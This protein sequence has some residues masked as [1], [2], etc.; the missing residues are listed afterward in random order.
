MF[1]ASLSPGSV[2]RWAY[3][4]ARY[5]LDPSRP[6]VSLANRCTLVYRSRSGQP[7]GSL[8]RQGDAGFL[9]VVDP[10]RR[11]RGIASKLLREAL[12][13]WPLDLGRERYTTAGAAFVNAFLSGDPF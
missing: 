1:D 7:L 9:V 12:H 5:A 4:A 6:G 10:R 2:P 3:L 13:R 8:Q 11:R